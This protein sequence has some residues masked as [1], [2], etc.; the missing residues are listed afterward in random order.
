MGV[1]RTYGSVNRPVLDRIPQSARRILDVGCGT[2]DLGAELKR[3]SKGLEV[4][5]ITRSREKMLRAQQVLDEV[6]LMDL[7]TDS[8]DGLGQFDCIVCSHVLEHLRD[9]RSVL[10]RLRQL[11]VPAGLNSRRASKCI[12]LAPAACIHAGGI[13]LYR[14]WSHG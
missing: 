4:I 7:E 8:L 12:A 14:W 13:S 9:P 2:G 10:E 1:G 11:L 6:F 3:Q 5:G